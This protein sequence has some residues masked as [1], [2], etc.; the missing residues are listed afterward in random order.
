MITNIF[1]DL[2]GVLV[3]AVPLHQKSFLM[4]I[5]MFGIDMSEDEHMEL[6]NG[7][8]TKEK[9]KILV[10][11][12]R[13]STQ[14]SDHIFKIKQSITNDLILTE[15]I[16]MQ[17]VVDTVRWASGFYN[18]SIFSNSIRSTIIKILTSAGL[19][20]LFKNSTIISNEDINYPK[21]DPSG[22][23]KLLDLNRCKPNNV[24]VI[25]DTDLGV[26]SAKAAGINNI[27]VVSSPADLNLIKL[28]EFI[29]D[30]NNANGRRS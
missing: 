29:R 16:S 1:F 10:E 12:N 15:I 22:Y 19:I 3:D 14:D 13:L 27:L 30:C 21:P 18:M 24:I 20:E 23:L 17:N 26:A 4:A 8:P 11:Q 5:K 2:D 6:F 9:L 28:K 25:E 7:R